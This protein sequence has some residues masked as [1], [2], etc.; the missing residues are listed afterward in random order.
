MTTHVPRVRTVDVAVKYSCRKGQNVFAHT[1]TTAFGRRAAA[2][3]MLVQSAFE[4]GPLLLL[5]L[6]AVSNFVG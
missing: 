2:Q 3:E 5:V 1:R 4:R 6:F